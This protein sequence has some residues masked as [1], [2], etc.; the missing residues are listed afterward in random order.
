MKFGCLI[1]YQIRN[2][3]FEKLYTEYGEETNPRPFSE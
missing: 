1:E 3:F 2:I